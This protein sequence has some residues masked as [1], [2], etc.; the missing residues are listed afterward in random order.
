ME[1]DDWKQMVL[2]V[3]ELELALGDGVKRVEENELETQVVQRRSIRLRTDLKS[4][5]VI[6]PSHLEFLRPAPND[7]L[8][9][10]KT[11]EIIGR[12]INVSRVKGDYLRKTDFD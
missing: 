9:L 3:H 10:S 7:H 8:G 2:Q 5:T 11:K 6:E 4:G 1:P 12:R